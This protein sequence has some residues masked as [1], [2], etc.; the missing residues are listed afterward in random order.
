MLFV[1]RPAAWHSINARKSALHCCMSGG[2]PESLS[3]KS[4]VRSH[5]W[6]AVFSR[7]VQIV[8]LWLPKF[9]FNCFYRVEFFAWFYKF[10]LFFPRFH[11]QDFNHFGSLLLKDG[12]TE[13]SGKS[14]KLFFLFL[15]FLKRDVS[16]LNET[17]GNFDLRLPHQH[18]RWL[19]ADCCTF[20]LE[21]NLGFD[22]ATIFLMQI[23]SLLEKQEEAKRKKHR[24]RPD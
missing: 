16:D 7:Q 20:S 18:Q 14:L 1:E 5:G 9:F 17:G 3:M 8:L 21:R 11:R 23:H 10:C 22:P 4:E 24:F 13:S 19:L 15:L 6:S 2:L 12:L